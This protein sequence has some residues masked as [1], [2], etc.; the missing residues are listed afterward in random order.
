M[1]SQLRASLR[2]EE[3]RYRSLDARA[4]RK[5]SKKKEANNNY[6]NVNQ[7]FGVNGFTP[8]LANELLPIDETLKGERLSW[9]VFVVVGSLLIA[10]GVVRTLLSRWHEYYHP[11]W[12]GT[13]VRVI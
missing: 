13:L 6:Y 2:R 12:G 3:R 9:L 1:P 7:E 8:T 5:V 11:L 4:L 10:C